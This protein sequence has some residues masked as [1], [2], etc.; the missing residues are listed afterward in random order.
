MMSDSVPT[1]H[2]T[3]CQYSCHTFRGLGKQSD[4]ETASMDP[5][6]YDYNLVFGA[7]TVGTSRLLIECALGATDLAECT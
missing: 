1:F 4:R 2:S 7:D 3:L 6:I 5:R